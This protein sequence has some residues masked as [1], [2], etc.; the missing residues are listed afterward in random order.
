MEKIIYAI[1]LLLAFSSCRSKQ[2]LGYFDDLKYSE[3][4]SIKLSDYSI[5]IEPEDELMITVSSEIPAATAQYNLPLSNP[6][7]Q[8]DLPSATLSLGNGGE[9]SSSSLRQPTYIVD[10]KG[11]ID[12]PVLGSIHVEGL[13]TSELKEYLKGAISRDV[14]DPHVRVVLVNFKVN[15]LGEV[16]TPQILNVP[17]ERFS[18]MDAIAACG[19][20]SPYGKRDNIIVMREQSD[21]TVTY[22]R[23]N[24]HDSSII[25]SPY[26]YLKQ[27]DVVYVEPNEVKQN[28]SKYDQQS[29]YKLSVISTIVSACSVIASLII[30]LAVK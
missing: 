3:S 11:N 22:Q 6:T 16:M 29:G 30:A 15:V 12:F 4:G 28:N 25:S 17:G 18:I 10:K 7:S 2:D 8:S 21:G 20:L 9:T 19:D 13:T 27:N 1:A 24:L 5:K 26:Y 23:L 14:K